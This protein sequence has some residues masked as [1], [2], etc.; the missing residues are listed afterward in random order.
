[1]A[2][3]L[4]VSRRSIGRVVKRD[5]EMRSFKLRRVHHLSTSEREKSHEEQGTLNRHAII[6]RLESFVFTD[7]KLFTIEEIHNTQNDRIISSSPENIPEELRYD[8]APAHTSNATQAWLRS[9][10]PNFIRKEEWTPYSPDFNPM[11]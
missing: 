4:K 2:S 10:N 6:H 11:E 5:L 9:N 3:E 7:G 1:M 8:G